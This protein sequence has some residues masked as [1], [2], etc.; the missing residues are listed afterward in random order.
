M[1]R[2][3]KPKV[4]QQ[5]RR[6]WNERLQ[7]G[8]GITKIAKGANRDIRLVK[9][10]IEIAQEELQA[11]KVRHDFLLGRMEL[12]QNDLLD[13]VNRLKAMVNRCTSPMN[14]TGETRQVNIHE[15]FLEH[16]KFL[17]L[18]EMLEIF[19]D[20]VMEFQ[21]TCESVKTELENKEKKLLK[22][23]P[24]EID[25]Y[26]WTP[27]LLVAVKTGLPL[28]ESGRTYQK[29]RQNDGTFKILWGA[30]HLTRSSLTEEDAELII[31]TH[32]EL[33]NCASGFQRVFKDHQGKLAE[34]ARPITEELDVLLIKRYVPGN[35][36]Y[37][38]V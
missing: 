8:E 26:P 25:I 5:E 2:K 3:R 24:K 12:H 9:K 35:C 19:H 16:I 4:S 30:G 37:C 38:P 20:E 7:N 29:E 31:K 14:P 21:E 15:A 28:D 36:K 6:R 1:A 33:L 27:D 18:K 34:S 11:S 10:Q 13:E 32:Q 17:K 23:L 22:T